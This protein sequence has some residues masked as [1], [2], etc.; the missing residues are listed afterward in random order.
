M[1]Y[2]MDGY[3]FLDDDSNGNGDVDMGDINEDDNLLF[4]DACGGPDTE[5]EVTKGTITGKDTLHAYSLALLTYYV[6]R[7]GCSLFE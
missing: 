7:V 4:S 5:V 6:C 3:L 1:L 2:L